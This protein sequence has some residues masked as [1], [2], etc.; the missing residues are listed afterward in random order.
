MIDVY[1]TSKPVYMC[2][3][4]HRKCLPYKDYIILAM[5]LNIDLAIYDYYANMRKLQ[6]YLIGFVAPRI[7]YIHTL[8]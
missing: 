1:F 6:P 4:Q 8:I 7:Y 2:D 5:K 3:T